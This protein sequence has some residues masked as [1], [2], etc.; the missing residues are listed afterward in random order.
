MRKGYEKIIKRI[1]RVSKHSSDLL[2]QFSDYLTIQEADA[3]Y[4]TIYLRYFDI[5][6][7]LNKDKNNEV[8]Q[9]DQ[10]EPILNELTNYYEI[11]LNEYKIQIDNV[12]KKFNNNSLTK[13]Q[14]N[15]I[16]KSL[17]EKLSYLIKHST[18]I[19]KLILQTE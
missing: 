8:E 7:E 18:F 17:K 14:K 2:Q 15:D 11:V 12:N 1:N 10:I 5:K 6:N 9:N 13:K 4:D 19:S 3:I 16:N